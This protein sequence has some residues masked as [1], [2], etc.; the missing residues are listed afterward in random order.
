MYIIYNDYCRLI[1]V[2]IQDIRR[3]MSRAKLSKILLGVFHSYCH[4]SSFKKL[5]FVVSLSNGRTKE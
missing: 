1:E 2:M 3:T 4:K 5:L